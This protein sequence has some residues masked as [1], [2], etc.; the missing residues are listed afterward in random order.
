MRRLVIALLLSL[1][2]VIVSHSQNTYPSIGTD[3]L[4]TITPEQLKITNLIFSEHDYLLK[5]VDL[6]NNQVS[7]LEKLNYLY[8]EQDSLRCKEIDQYKNAYED[9]YKKYN[10]LN[11]RYKITKTVSLGSILILL[12]ALL[13]R[14]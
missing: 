8:I 12:G 9:S 7:D 2:T 5:K 14:F 1:S 11:K 13:W 6:L 3:S 4:V 10:R